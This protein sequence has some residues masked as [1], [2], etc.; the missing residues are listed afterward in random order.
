VVLVEEAG[1]VVSAYDGS[2]FVI[3]TGR[4]LAC[5]SGLQQ[6]LIEGLSHC[7]PLAGASYGAPELDAPRLDP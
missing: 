7:Q 2:A 1:G 4:I 3:D 5:G 6:P